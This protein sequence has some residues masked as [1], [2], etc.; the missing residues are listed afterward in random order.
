ML[1]HGQGAP[2]HGGQRG[3]AVVA[4]HDAARLAAA[5]RAHGVALEHHDVGQPELDQG[6]GRAETRH[7]ATDDHDLGRAGRTHGP[8]EGQPGIQPVPAKGTRAMAAA[9]TVSAARSS[10][11]R[12]CTLDFPQARASAVTSMVRARK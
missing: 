4:A 3:D 2:G 1:E 5:A 6:A 12:W 8:Q 7:A 10:G 9:S 11:S